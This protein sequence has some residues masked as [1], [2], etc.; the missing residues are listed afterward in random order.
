MEVPQLEGQ[1][2][3]RMKK[4]EDSIRDLW[5]HIKHTNIRIIGVP[6]GEEREKGTENLFEEIMAENFPNLAQET[7]IQVQETQSPK[8]DEPK[9]THTKTHYNYIVES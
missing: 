5:D 8:Q 4:N 9:E 6:E 3:K 2:E 1:K 7:D